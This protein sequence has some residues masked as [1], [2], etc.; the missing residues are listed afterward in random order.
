[1][2]GSAELNDTWTIHDSIWSIMHPVVKIYPFCS[3]K[4]HM[5]YSAS[6][7]GLHY[8]YFISQNYVIGDEILI[9][10]QLHN[11]TRSQ[12]L[13]CHL[14]QVGVLSVLAWVGLL[15][16][17]AVLSH[18]SYVNVCTLFGGLDANI[19]MHLLLIIFL[20]SVKGRT[21][22]TQTKKGAQSVILIGPRPIQAPALGCI[23]GSWEGGTAGLGS[24]P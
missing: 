10:L 12:A 22:S 3:P 6:L 18:I 20:S 15:S 8:Y 24:T 4:F 1:L 17:D 5:K 14:S 23:D 7:M 11:H 21:V 19:R 16:I 9:H 2:G 13:S